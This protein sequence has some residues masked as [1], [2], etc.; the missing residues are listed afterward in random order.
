MHKISY[1]IFFVLFSLQM[2]FAGDFSSVIV[3]PDDQKAQALLQMEDDFTQSWSNFDIQ[4]RLGKAEGS[5]AE[6]LALIPKEVLSWRDKE[7]AR[8]KEIAG[9][10]DAMA[11]ELNWD[12]HLPDT[13]YIIKTSGKEEGG[14]EGYTRSNYIVL[15]EEAVRG[16]EKALQHL[17]SHELFHI[18]SRAN[19]TL[20]AELYAIIGF[21]I[22]KPIDYPEEIAELRIT[23]PDATQTDAY[24]SLKLDGQEQN[25]MM[26]LYA[27]EEYSGGSFF[28]YLQIGFLAL[29]EN[30]QVLM[31]DGVA[32]IY[33]LR[34]AKGFINQIGQNTQY[35]IHPEE[36]LAENF[37]M[38]LWGD[39][40]PSPKIIA[41]IQELMQKAP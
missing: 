4:A 17:L 32:K 37:S 27:K 36:I 16:K 38:A 8:I 13:I 6:L 24:I 34:E 22:M 12:L 2:V 39:K 25:A 15:K 41:Q 21:K 7:K 14:A 20:R 19:P 33:G 31:E 18:I 10:I 40:A 35:I 9:E 30:H 23:N 5:K 3:F 11:K 1:P 26:V 29:D 28:E